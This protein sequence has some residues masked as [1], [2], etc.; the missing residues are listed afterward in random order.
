MQ[1]VHDNPAKALMVEYLGFMRAIQLW[2]HGA[3]HLTRGMSFGGDH[4]NIYGRIY[5]D[6]EAQ[7]D[8][9]IEKAI[10]IFGD[11]AG[12]PIMITSVALGIMN[13]YGTPLDMPVQSIAA[14]GLE[15]EKDFLKFSQNLYDTLKRLN[16]MTLG[17]DDMIMANANAHETF[18]YLLQQRLKSDMSM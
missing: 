8:G 9:G 16:M 12:C 6:V 7:I 2:F 1:Y 13:E 3:H 14:I 10:G 4:V 17:L 5:T 15:I 18:V 11:K